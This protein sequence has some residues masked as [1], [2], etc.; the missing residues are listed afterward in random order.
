MSYR[1]GKK[2]VSS[3]GDFSFKPEIEIARQG[4]ISIRI[5]LRPEHDYA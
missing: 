4:S 2:V 1:K 3:K 5:G